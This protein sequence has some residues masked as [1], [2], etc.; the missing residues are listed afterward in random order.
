MEWQWPR[1]ELFHNV[2]HLMT[3]ETCWITFGH[4][5]C[6]LYLHKSIFMSVMKKYL[7]QPGSKCR[8]FYKDLKSC[9]ITHEKYP[10]YVFFSY[11][12]ILLQFLCQRVGM[13]LEMPAA[14]VHASIC[15]ST[16]I[17]WHQHL[18]HLGEGMVIGPPEMCQAGA[19]LLCCQ[20][21]VRDV[22]FGWNP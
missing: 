5:A 20:R 12:V 1:V 15:A 21:A 7:K 11:W 3:V 4:F 14:L 22:M 2:F 13:R 18:G 19:L 6:I 17:V 10:Y 16:H 8:F 9:N